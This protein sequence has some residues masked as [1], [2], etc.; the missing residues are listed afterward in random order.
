MTADEARVG[1]A[2]ADRP[3]AGEPLALGA[4]AGKAV[5]GRAP[6]RPRYDAVII[7]SGLGGATLANRLA[8]SG[9]KVLVVERGEALMPRRRGP[10]DPVGRYIYTEVPDAAALSYIGG[11]TK[12]YGAALYRMRE[13]DFRAVEH[14]SGTSP[15]W[16]IDYAA[17][18]PYYEQGEAMYRVHGAPEGDASEPP[19]RAPYPY[20]PIPE[21]PL[22]AEMTARLATSGTAVAAIPRGLDYRPGGAC[23]LCATCDAHYCQLDAKMDAD[24]AALRPALAT[25]N[26]QVAAGTDCL[27]VVV[28]G[29]GRRA[30][31]VDLVRDGEAFHVQA[32]T[33][34]V[35]AGLP[36]T[37]ILLRRS[38]TG[39]HPDG[40][41]NEGGALGRYLGAHSV[42]MLFP[43]V[44][45]R[46]LPPTHTK[47]FAINTFYDASPGWPYPTGVLQTA[48]QT[49]FWKTTSRAIRPIAKLI[50]QH[51]ITC[52]YMTEALPTRETGVI[53]G[54]GDTYRRVDAVL[55]A[56]TFF[57]MRKLARAAFHR[58]GYRTF[59]RKRAPYQWHEVGTARFGEDPA[60]SVAD[61]H[62]QVH[63]IAGLYV[64]DVSV[65]PSAGAVNTGLTL[66]ALALR[67]GDHITGAMAPRPVYGAAA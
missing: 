38:R 52:F 13:S 40:L 5:S 48:G 39:A 47:S 58:A 8:Q 21:V 41:G 26:L 24:T 25:G 59:A 51:S 10:Q 30:V 60:T 2:F 14:E 18:E 11:Q 57:R 53:F 32:N 63:G 67:A 16:P 45:L 17:L 46:N 54:E 33:V 28:D 66:V 34:A 4:P 29:S 55:N 43:F 6:I 15:A 12:F 23:V 9:R 36:R 19:R 50:G 44:S 22:I 7:G 56:Q 65:L 20:P 49:P 1:E 35:C 31:G 37:A 3:S 27:R 42:G 64:V 61:P 62:C